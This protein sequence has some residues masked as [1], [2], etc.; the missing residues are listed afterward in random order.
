ASREPSIGDLF[1]SRSPVPDHSPQ[2]TPG[3]VSASPNNG[4]TSDLTVL[5]TDFVSTGDRTS[6][7]LIKLSYFGDRADPHLRLYPHTRRDGLGFPIDPAAPLC[8]KKLAE[9]DRFLFYKT[10]R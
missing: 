1:S 7:S 3:S 8:V 2:K 4:K 10:C 9:C 6:I 5:T